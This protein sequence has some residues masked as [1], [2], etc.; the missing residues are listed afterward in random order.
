M[1]HFIFTNGNDNLKPCVNA[2]NYIDVDLVHAKVTLTNGGEL[3][4]NRKAR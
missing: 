2:F 1:N 4:V 3:D